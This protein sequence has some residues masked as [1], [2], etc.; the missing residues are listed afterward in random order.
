MLVQLLQ[1]S[2]VGPINVPSFGAGQRDISLDDLHLEG[3]ICFHRRGTSGWIFSRARI[4]SDSG[5]GSPY[6]VNPTVK[7]QYFATELVQETSSGVVVLHQQE[8]QVG[9]GDAPR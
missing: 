4:A 8:A 5:V 7:T 6:C 1:H 2:H 3:I 9:L